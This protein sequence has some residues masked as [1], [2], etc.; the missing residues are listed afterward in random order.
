MCNGIIP[1]L[2]EFGNSGP[3]ERSNSLRIESN[4][5]SNRFVRE[6][7]K[8]KVVS[9][10]Q[11]IA[12]YIFQQNNERRHVVKTIGNFC[13][14]QLLQFLNWPA[15]SPDVSPIEH[16]WDSVGRH[17]TLDLHPAASKHKLWLCIQAIWNSLSQEDNQNQFNCRIAARDGSIK[18]WFRTLSF[19]LV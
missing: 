6:V 14:V 15:Y 4:L 3:T 8:P 11:G 5:N 10:L 19:L 18:Y 16:V 13:W 12:G 9:F 7:R 17:L 1:Q 2:C